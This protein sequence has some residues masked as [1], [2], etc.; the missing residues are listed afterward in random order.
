[1]FEYGCVFVSRAVVLILGRLVADRMAGVGWRQVE[2]RGEER[3][4]ERERHTH[5]NRERESD[6]HILSHLYA[7][8]AGILHNIK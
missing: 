3:G 1:M 7:S 5:R 2:R 6:I 8:M 4:R